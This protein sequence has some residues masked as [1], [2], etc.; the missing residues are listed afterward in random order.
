LRHRLS[1]AILLIFAGGA[2][3]EPVPLDYFD[4]PPF[5]YASDGQPAGSVMALE[6]SIIA[7]LDIALRPEPMPLRRLN[8]EAGRAPLIVAAIIRSAPRERL[9]QWIGRLCVDPF[10]MAT[11][12]PNPAIDSLEEARRLKL[13]AVVSGASNETFLRDHGFANLDVAASIE[14][15]VRRLAEGHDDAWFAPRSGVLHA[16]K[17]AGHDPAQLRFGAPIA[18]MEIWM[19]A[20][21]S[22][23]KPL[24]ET[25]RRRFAEQVRSGAVAAATGCGT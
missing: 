6:R 7:G 21:N 11:R 10:V 5:S 12:A 14:L 20:S 4:L 2:S 1:F 9:Y 3:A 25:L 15:E 22:V 19:A 13:I 17:A 23:P 8:F 24:V 18:A 16:W